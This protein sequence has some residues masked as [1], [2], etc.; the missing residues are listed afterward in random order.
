MTYLFTD[1]KRQNMNEVSNSKYDWKTIDLVIKKEI[2]LLPNEICDTIMDFLRCEECFIG[3]P[4][5]TWYEKATKLNK[6]S[7]LKAIPSW[8]YGMERVNE[9]LFIACKSKTQNNVDLVKYL[10]EQGANIKAKYMWNN[11][12]LH[13]ACDFGY[14]PL[15]FQYLDVVKYLVEQGADVNAADDDNYDS[16]PLHYAC[17]S[18]N[19]DMVKYLVEQGANVNAKAWG[20]STP[21]H[22]ACM[23]GNLEIVKYLVEQGADVEA[24]A[25]TKTTP[26]CYAC[27][28]RHLEV[29]KYLIEEKGADVFV[30]W[31]TDDENDIKEYL[32]SVI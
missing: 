28:N 13:Y 12:P 9:L 8:G 31:A 14:T 7:A 23:K 15:S 17:R 5:D 32:R 24:K 3:F 11:T 2:K 27:W 19:P 16:T 26:L 20:N 18:K 30:F 29:V 21:F 22:D 1:I 10:V 25:G 6:L 4:N